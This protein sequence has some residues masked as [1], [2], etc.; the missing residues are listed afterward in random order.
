MCG[1]M[2]IH[3][4]VNLVKP[5][6]L[7]LTRAVP[8]LFSAALRLPWLLAAAGAA[9]CN[10]HPLFCASLACL[11][12]S[13]FYVGLLYIWQVWD[14]WV[15]VRCGAPQPPPPPLPCSPPPLFHS[16]DPP[17]LP[18]SRPPPPA[19][20]LP[21]PPLRFRLPPSPPPPPP[22]AQLTSPPSTPPSPIPPAPTRYRPA[23]SPPR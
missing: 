15:P 10:S 14:G 6:L 13:F 21:H 11:A 5:L 12:C 7:L 1:R 9:T 20:L 8:V 17:P 3:L 4:L 2:L 23:P 19:A 16:L 22:P 18:L